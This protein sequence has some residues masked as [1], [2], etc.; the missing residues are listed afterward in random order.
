VSGEADILLADDDEVGRYVVATMLRR[1]G[2]SVRETGDGASAVEEALRHPPALALLDVKMPVMDGFEAC[3]RLKSHELTRH[4]PVLLLSATFLDTEAQVEGL[5]TGADAYLTQP[6]EAPVLAATVRSLL[7][8]R[9]A[10]SDVRHAALQWRTTFDAID[11]AV[12]VLSGDLVLERLN[13]S[14]AAL[15]GTEDPGELV[16]RRLDELAPEL[17]SIVASGGAGELQ[18]GPRVLRVRHDA[19]PSDP[20]RNLEDQVVVTLTDVTAARRAETER[21]EALQRE[22][23]ISRTLQQSLLPERLPRHPALHLDAWHLAAEKE[24]IVGGDWYDVIET[25][26]TV[27]LVIGDVA[28]HGVAAATQAGQLRHS[29]RVY[30]HE[31]YDLAEAVHRLNELVVGTELT[32]MATVCIAAVELETGALELVRAGHPPPL[33]IPAGGEPH[34]LE[35]RAGVVLGVPGA[36]CE[37]FSGTLAP[38]DRLVLYTDGLIELP[39]ESLDVGLGRLLDAARGVG[40]LRELR[41][42]LVERMV[43]IADLRDDVAL[44]LAE[45][46]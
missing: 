35:G 40:G 8:A 21:A 44:L 4:V 30:A 24:L 10:E 13:R 5:E 41:E 29:L 39:D 46:A 9:R 37:Q 33:M 12:A 6:V 22:R 2:F 25:G 18:L 31:G 19:I 36:R 28:G 45:R 11:D 17:P 1:A 14:F 3:R 42:G 26:G 43:D 34:L 23:T 20:Q 16:G 15:F 32:G 27:W 7:R 38:G